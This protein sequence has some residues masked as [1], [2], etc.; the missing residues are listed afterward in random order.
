MVSELTFF[1]NI[2]STAGNNMVEITTESATEV[3]P[4]IPTE[5]IILIGKNSNALRLINTARPLKK[6]AFPAVASV[7]ATASITDSVRLISCRKRLT[8]NKA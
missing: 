4:P 7:I 2:P 5:N 3:I 6:T 8:I 1:P